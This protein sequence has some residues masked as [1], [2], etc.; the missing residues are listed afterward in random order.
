MRWIILAIAISGCQPDC[1]LMCGEKGVSQHLK[2]GQSFELCECKAG[3]TTV[4]KPEDSKVTAKQMKEAA[5]AA[6]EA[7]AAA[8]AAA[9]KVA[10]KDE[11]TFTL[12]GEY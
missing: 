9:E 10:K 12:E 4:K 7:A 2:I 1:M 5:N 8:A 3:K 11:D 6:K